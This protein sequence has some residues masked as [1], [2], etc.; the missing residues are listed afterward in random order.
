MKAWEYYEKPKDVEYFGY[1]YKKQYEAAE[2]ARINDTRLTTAERVIAL[3]KLKQQIREHMREKNA[4]YNEACRVLISEFWDDARE[5]LGYCAYLTPEGI[6]YLEYQAYEDGHS[7]GFG[8]V[9]HNLQER[10]N[11][12]LTLVAE[13]SAIHTPDK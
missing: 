8:R 5:E 11:F 9:Y 4:P 3:D 7:S 13:Y 1:D 10:W 6:N 2:I 12:F